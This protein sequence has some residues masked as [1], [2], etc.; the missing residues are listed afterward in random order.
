MSLWY[1]CLTIEIQ[2]A[3]PAHC[4]LTRVFLCELINISLF[5]I[6]PSFYCV[7]E[8]TYGL[9]LIRLEQISGFADPGPQRTRVS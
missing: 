7:V 8:Y 9:L 5:L 2:I 4:K 6:D 1:G 3:S